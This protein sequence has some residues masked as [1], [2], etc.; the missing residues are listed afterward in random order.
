MSILLWIF[1]FVSRPLY[2]IPFMWEAREFLR[3]KLINSNV[4]VT[5][6]YIQPANNDY[7][8]KMCGTVTIGGVNIAEALVARGL[9][10]VVIYAADND[11][12]SSHYDDLLAAEDKAKK[13]NKVRN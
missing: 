10:T 12:R 11:R 1:S 3:K 2:D 6:D 9:A 5:I 4:H 8:E 7:P 13:S